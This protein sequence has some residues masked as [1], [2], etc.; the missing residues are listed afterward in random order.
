LNFLRDHEGARR[1][2]VQ[3]SDINLGI[4]GETYHVM[5]VEKERA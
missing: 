1:A 2:V 4:M 3:D 5:V